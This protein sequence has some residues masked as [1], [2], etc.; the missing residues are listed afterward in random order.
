VSELAPAQL[1]RLIHMRCPGELALLAFAD[2]GSMTPLLGPKFLRH[3]LR[4]QARI[5]NLRSGRDGPS[6]M[7]ALGAAFSESSRGDP[8]R[9]P[10]WSM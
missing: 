8:F 7:S 5:W 10:G 1:D 4:A 3:G 6:N 2:A 9:M